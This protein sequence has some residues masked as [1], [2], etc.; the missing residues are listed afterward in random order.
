VDALDAAAALR[1][2]HV[3][4]AAAEEATLPGVLWRHAQ[5]AESAV[6]RVRVEPS[7]SSEHTTS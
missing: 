6:D 4:Q 2:P 5:R 1:Q 3:A 7:P